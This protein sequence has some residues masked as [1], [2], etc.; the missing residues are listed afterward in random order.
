MAQ[1]SWRLVVTAIGASGPP[2]HEVTVEADNWMGAIRAGRAAIGESGGVPTGASCAVSPDG[3][4]TILDPVARRSYVLAAETSSFHPPAAPTGP[5]VP[6]DQVPPPP[7]AKKKVSKATV[8]YMVPDD[9]KAAFAASQGAPKVVAVGAPAPAPTPAPAAVAEPVVD[10]PISMDSVPPPAPAPVAAPA[11]APVAAAPAPAPAPVDAAAKKKAMSRTMAYMPAPSSSTSQPI[12]IGGQPAP[13]AQPQAAAYA[14]APAPVAQPQPAAYAPAV[15][16]A[17][18]A[19]YSQAPAAPVAPPQAPAAPVAQP[20][21]PAPVAQPQA[22]AP[23]PVP[24]PQAPAPVAPAPAPVAVA[25]PPAMTLAQRDESPTPQSPIHYRER[26][27]AIAEG[28][29]P[30]IAEQ[31]ARRELAALQAALA[32]APTGKF[33]NIAVFDHA[34]RERPLRAPVV[35]LQWKDWRGEPEVVFPAAKRAKSVT[36]APRKRSTTAE[37][38][39][40]RLAHA[41]EACQDLFFLSS[42]ADGLDF[43]VRLLREAIPSDAITAAL[44]DI[45]TD[46][47]RFVALD[48]IGANYRK[49]DAIPSRVGLIG[50]AAHAPTPMLV[51]DL[52]ADP[53]FDPGVDGRPELEAR[54]MLLTSCIHEGRLLGVLQLVNRQKLPHFTSADSNVVAYVSG[55]LAAFLYQMRVKADEKPKAGQRRT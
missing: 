11:P 13:V 33:V 29:A 49:G 6:A 40:D 54:N 44:Y 28:I 17:P 32:H 47:I 19:A 43:V 51:G 23:A 36:P 34:W 16:Y 3:R 25:L 18:A 30:G 10:I 5:R 22:P 24:Q 55:Q 1:K 4:V 41:F 53:R 35:T 39:D 45:N 46:E 48:G 31:V 9:I 12:V 42:P 38:H 20:Q 27:F 52:T 8:G 15:A 26:A 14:P 50:V 21:A 7:E 2:L 37:A